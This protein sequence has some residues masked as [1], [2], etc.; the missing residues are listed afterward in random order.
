MLIKVTLDTNYCGTEEQ[1]VYDV[2]DH[3][4]DTIIEDFVGELAYENAVECG[5]IEQ[6][7]WDI[8][9]EYGEEPISDDEFADLLDD[10]MGVFSEWSHC[11]EAEREALLEEY[12]IILKP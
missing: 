5:I 3:W 9:E 2:P 1:R 4:T 12:G 7:E 11:E 6:A 8:E 10:K